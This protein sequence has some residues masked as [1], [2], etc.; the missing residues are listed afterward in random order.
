MSA[1][2]GDLERRLAENVARLRVRIATAA[3]ASGR[4]AECVTLVAATKYL[5]AEMARQLALAGCRAFQM[6]DK[7]FSFGDEIVAILQGLSPA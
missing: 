6:R 3:Q 4:A 7:S 5:N 2:T 1:A